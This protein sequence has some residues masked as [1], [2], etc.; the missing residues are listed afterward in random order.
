MLVIDQVMFLDLLETL[1]KYSEASPF[2]N[3]INIA[4]CAASSL[5]HVI[6]MALSIAVMNA[7]TV[8]N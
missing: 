5:P 1:C 4:P 6:A 8:A 2:L 3:A 7:A